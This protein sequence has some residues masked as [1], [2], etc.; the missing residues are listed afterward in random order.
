MKYVILLGLLLVT[1]AGF[2][3]EFTAPTMKAPEIDGRIRPDEWKTA[4]RYDTFHAF[5]RVAAGEPVPVETTVFMGS[6]DDFLYFAF[7]CANRPGMPPLVALR[8]RDS[9]VSHD[10]SVEVFLNGS[11]KSNH[12]LQLSVSASGVCADSYVRGGASAVDR[13]WNSG[14]WRAAATRNDGFYEVEIAVPFKIIPLDGSDFLTFNLTRTVRAGGNA[15]LTLT[16]M[17]GDGWHQP[18]KFSRLSAP[19]LANYNK[20]TARLV[21]ENVQL[22]GNILRSTVENHAGSKRE[23]VL[24]LF[25]NGVELTRK[26]ELKPREKQSL[27]IP[28]ANNTGSIEFFWKLVSE[29]RELYVAAVRRHTIVNGS[30]LPPPFSFTGRPIICKLNVNYDVAT[31]AGSTVEILVRRD[32]KTVRTVRYPAF[33]SDPEL[34]SLEPGFYGTV[35][36]VRGKDGRALFSNENSFWVVSRFL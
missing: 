14:L 33:T 5:G 15:Y 26:L 18:E 13:S 22:G 12:Y 1:L 35:V 30:F 3:M 7:R 9:N 34:P 31:L 19:G 2:A 20:L 16:P 4:K 24:S 6:D 27:E 28:W 23:A 11:P 21:W 17:T 29:E 25:F 32:E 10:D 36:T 8:E